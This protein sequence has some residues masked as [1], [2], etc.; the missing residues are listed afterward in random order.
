MVPRLGLGS[1]ALAAAMCVGLCGPSAESPRPDTPQVGSWQGAVA[2]AKAP[3]QISVPTTAEME[4]DLLVAL[5]EER[6]ARNLTAV[7]LTPE[8]VELARRHSADQA[9]RNE[10]SHYS[11]TGRSYQQRLQDAG[12]LSVANGENVGRSETFLTGPIHQSFMDS[13]THRD[14][15]LNPAY[16]AVGI[17]VVRGERSGRDVYFVTVD[18]I[19]RVVVKTAADIRAKML[20]ALNE[21][22]ARARLAPVELFDAVNAMADKHA[23]AEAEGRVLPPVAFNT[24]RSSTRFFSSLDL[25]QIAG[26]IRDQRVEGFGLAGIGSAFGRNRQHPEGA[27]VIC[28]ILVWNG[29]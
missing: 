6:A 11:A 23:Q 18:F 28:V 13:P 4:A 21:A 8:L 7:R 20:T 14:N 29:K 12:I 27:Y 10:L 15:I 16:D 1:I 2:Q 17:G 24:W 9:A 3:P 22:R 5:N 25:D 26:S 19:K